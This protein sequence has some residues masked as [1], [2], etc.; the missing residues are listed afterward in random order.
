MIESP[1]LPFGPPDHKLAAPS[2]DCPTRR[3]VVLAAGSLALGLLTGCGASPPPSPS[4]DVARASTNGDF[5]RYK[6]G[7]PYT[8][9]GVTYTPREDFYYDERGIASWYGPGFQGRQTAN[10]EIFDQT[11]LTAAHPT[12]QM[13]SLVRVTNLSNGRSVVLR[14]N[15]RGP[16]ARGRIIDLSRRGAELL[17]FVE[18]GVVPV[19][20]QVLTEESMALAQRAGREG[21]SPGRARSGVASTT[22]I[23]GTTLDLGRTMPDGAVRQGSAQPVRLFVQVGAFQDVDNARRLARDLAPIG[24]AAVTPT[25]VGGRLFNRVRLGPFATVSAADQVL[26]RVVAAGQSQAELRLD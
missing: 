2:A 1:P 3:K 11:A 9:R 5:G 8:I 24:P 7:R 25:T 17:G 10:G 21:P 6:V 13:P 4:N 16:F 26:A 18:Q 23:P 14:V 19:R 12:L 15:D 20:V 22:S